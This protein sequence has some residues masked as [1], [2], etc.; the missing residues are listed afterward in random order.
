MGG[1]RLESFTMH[2][3]AWTLATTR[4]WEVG[5]RPNNTSCDIGGSY[6]ED[7]S[8]THAG[9]AALQHLTCLQHLALNDDDSAVSIVRDVGLTALQHVPTLTHLE[10]THLE[11]HYGS[12]VTD[13]G[14]A[15]LQHLPRLTHLQLHGCR[16]IKDSGLAALKHVAALT[17][18]DLHLFGG[19]SPTP[20]WV[21]LHQ[22]PALTSLLL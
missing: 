14:L 15:E 6:D 12:A 18:L 19:L 11:L 3:S 5:C 7:G 16:L 20:G 8:L 2:D 21:G 9:L 22:M 10:L 17:H 13:A 1:A 4:G